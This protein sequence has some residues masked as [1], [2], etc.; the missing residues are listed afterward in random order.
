MWETLFSFLEP[1]S[2]KRR[3]LSRSGTFSLLGVYLWGL[4]FYVSKI[5]LGVQLLIVT[6]RWDVQPSLQGFLMD[7]LLAG[8]GCLPLFVSGVLPASQ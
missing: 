7:A 5:S 8:N 1:S 2:Y 3:P 4:R 6:E